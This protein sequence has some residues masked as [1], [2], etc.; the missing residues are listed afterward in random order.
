[1]ISKL[2]NILKSTTRYVEKTEHKTINAS[3]KGASVMGPTDAVHKD[4]LTIVDKHQEDLHQ[5]IIS[6]HIISKL[7]TTL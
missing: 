2:I 6:N 5:W 7:H 4:L 3:G 1:M